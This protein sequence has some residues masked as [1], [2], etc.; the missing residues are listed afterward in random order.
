MSLAERT[1][2]FANQAPQMPN[3][4]ALGNSLLNLIE[5]MGAARYACLYLRREPGGYVIE[6]SIANVPPIF[7]EAYLE[8]GYDA[9]DP[10][11]QGAVRA[12][13]CGYWSEQTRNIALDR[14]GRE[15]MDI[16]SEHN[17][18]E[19]FTKR[20]MLD[21]GGIAVM[22]AAGQDMARDDRSRAALRMA[23]DIF[24]NEGAR[25]LKLSGEPRGD[26]PTGEN[27]LSRTQLRVL[28]MRAEGLSNRDIAGL[29]ARKEK[30]VECHVTE[31]LRR[32]E[33]RNMI[34]AIRIATLQRVIV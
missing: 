4:K 19:G 23:F 5:Q 21:N 30:T 7:Q 25:L 16:A 6:R 3:K 11:F 24:A 28:L 17:M 13:A 10:I 12:G 1:L 18:K 32:L 33:A 26:M 27:L 15:A 20:V 14:G 34:D 31:I 8:R 29:M 22:M 2:T 9:A